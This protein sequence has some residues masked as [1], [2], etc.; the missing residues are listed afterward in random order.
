MSKATRRKMIACVY[1]SQ[2]GLSQTLQLIQTA[3]A[4]VLT[5]TSITDHVSPDLAALH[6][7]PVKSRTESFFSPLKPLMARRH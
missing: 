4:R 6:W 7:L 1:C 2:A 5:R 3:A